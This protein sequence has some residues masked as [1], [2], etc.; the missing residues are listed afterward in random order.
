M[1]LKQ[2][3]AAVVCLSLAACATNGNGT[4]TGSHSGDKAA[5]GASVGAVA[6][7]LLCKS[8]G[9]SDVACRNVAIAAGTIG[10]L[11][12][13]KA[14]KAQDLQ[15]AQAFENVARAQ[16]IPVT[17]DVS[18]VEH[19]NSQG[20]RETVTAWKGT[21]VGLPP[22]L[23][24]QHNPDLKKTVQLAGRLA[25]SQHEQSVVLVS[26]PSKDR[27]AVMS[28]LE[29]GF[30]QGKSK[31]KP[32]VRMLEAKAGNVPFLRIQPANQQQFSASLDGGK[33]G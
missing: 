1:R 33:A 26:V 20:T 2:L 4:V 16:Q 27:R 12:G 23:L 14:G 25:A 7:Y 10:G 9:G 29:Q 15:E 30:S 13:W 31:S 8:A 3:C 19:T 18:D 21:T 32:S 11:I 5:V 28:W 6:G 22:T 24:A 17:T